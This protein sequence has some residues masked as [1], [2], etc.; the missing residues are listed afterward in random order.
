MPGWVIVNRVLVPAPKVAAVHALQAWV[1]VVRL[2]KE[3]LAPGVMQTPH[4]TLAVQALR[5]TRCVEEIARGRNSPL[6]I[7]E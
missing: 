2:I 6:E 5:N 3:Y 7:S 4:Q 1:L